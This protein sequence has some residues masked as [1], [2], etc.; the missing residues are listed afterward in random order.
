MGA[1]DGGSE[2]SD[3]NLDDPPKATGSAHAKPDLD[4]QLHDPG[5]ARGPS[6]FPA[7]TIRVVGVSEDFES[8][9]SRAVAANTW[10]RRW[11]AKVEVVNPRHAS[12][13]SV[14]PIGMANLWLGLDIHAAPFEPATCRALPPPR[15]RWHEDRGD[16]GPSIQCAPIRAPEPCRRTR[17]ARS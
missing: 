17:W 6:V 5:I 16:D 2:I 9:P 11:P 10:K 15:S 4:A 3:P 8:H 7:D 1:P 12:V 14:R 13:L